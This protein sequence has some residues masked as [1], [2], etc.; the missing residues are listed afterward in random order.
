MRRDYQVAQS[1]IKSV[2]RKQVDLPLTQTRGH[3]AL[4]VNF[5][6]AHSALAALVGSLGTSP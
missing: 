5:G 6:R 3:A 4:W 2:N 1:Q